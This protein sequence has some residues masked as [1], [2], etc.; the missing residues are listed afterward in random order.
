MKNQD[1]K[2]PTISIT[3]LPNCKGLKDLASQ[4]NLNSQYMKE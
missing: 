3:L 4:E 2:D 1:K